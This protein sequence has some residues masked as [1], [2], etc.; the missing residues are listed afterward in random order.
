MAGELDQNLTQAV[1]FLNVADMAASLAFYVDGLGFEIR[2]KWTP[3]DPEHIR[4][5]W[6][7]AGGAAMMLQEYLPSRVPATK[8]G[9]G[10][11]V[12]FMC[13]DAL[14]LHRSSAARGLH[15]RRPFVG[16]GL[17]VVSFV[18]PDGY[19]VEFESPTDVPEDTEYDP[20]LHG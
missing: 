5:C 17:W 12:C 10:V 20:T 16:S 18:D 4:W 14:A 15:A 11:S 7:G 1:P 8:R 6:L 19:I 13:K 2:Q 3:D 9:E